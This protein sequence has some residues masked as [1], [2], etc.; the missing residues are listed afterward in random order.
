MN[1]LERM[2]LWSLAQEFLGLP[3][4]TGEQPGPP[5]I[6]PPP[7]QWEGLLSCGTSGCRAKP[8]HTVSTERG[9][10]GAQQ[11][12]DLPS[13]GA[14]CGGIKPWSP[15]LQPGSKAST[16]PQLKLPGG[17]LP[18]SGPAM[19]GPKPLGNIWQD[20]HVPSLTCWPLAR[21]HAQP[22]NGDSLSKV[23]LCPH[24]I[25]PRGIPEPH[26]SYWSWG[27]SPFS[28]GPKS[29]PF[30]QSIDSSHL[31]LPPSQLTLPGPA[32]H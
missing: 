31:H 16:R 30:S 3:D 13:D 12:M 1:A 28:S 22:Q 10:P 8:A 27:S 2:A 29:F 17:Q 23:K 21:R 5:S 14:A 32:N 6:H 24:L 19:E 11:G 7:T 20:S 15:G 9:G 18:S 4:M 25:H 26:P